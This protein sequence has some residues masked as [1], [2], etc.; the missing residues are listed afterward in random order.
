MSVL[1]QAV[2]RRPQACEL[3]SAELGQFGKQIFELRSAHAQF[4]SENLESSTKPI[5]FANRALAHGLVN[6]WGYNTLSAFTPEPAY[7]ASTGGQ[8]PATAEAAAAV[9]AAV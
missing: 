5:L 6:H 4:S 9:L 7:A 2:C 3:L 1:V 8:D